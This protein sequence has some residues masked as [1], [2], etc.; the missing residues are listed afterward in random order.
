[1]AIS[2]LQLRHSSELFLISVIVE[3]KFL[4]GFQTRQ[5]VVSIK[6][7]SSERALRTW[8]VEGRVLRTLENSFDEVE[9]GDG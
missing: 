4:S 9:A 2:A 8:S 1:M 3:I 6:H 7:L 5:I